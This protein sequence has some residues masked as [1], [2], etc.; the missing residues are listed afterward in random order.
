MHTSNIRFLN[1]IG[2]L[3][4]TIV[5]FAITDY[6]RSKVSFSTSIIMYTSLLIVGIFILYYTDNNSHYE[7]P[8]QF[9]DHQ[10]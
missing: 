3:F 7:N 2:V 8:T 5:A 6:I 4:V 1:L 10:H 9:D